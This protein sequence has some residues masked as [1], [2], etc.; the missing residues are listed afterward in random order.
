MEYFYFKIKKQFK[1]RIKSIYLW[2][3]VNLQQLRLILPKHLEQ[4]TF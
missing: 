1:Y 3:I 2:N 4:T